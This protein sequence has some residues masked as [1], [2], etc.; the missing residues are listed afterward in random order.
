M[1]K[2]ITLLFLIYSFVSNYAQE[3][4]NKAL[5]IIYSSVYELDSLAGWKYNSKSGQWICRKNNIIGYDDFDKIQIKKISIDDIDYI[6]LFKNYIGGYYEY[7]AINLGWHSTIETGIYGFNKFEF[8]NSLKNIP[9][10]SIFDIKL[11]IDFKV[12]VI[13]EAN[14]PSEIMAT[15]NSTKLSNNDSLIFRIQISK[16]NNYFRLFYFEKRCFDSISDDEFCSFYRPIHKFSGS[17]YEFDKLYNYLFSNKIFEYMYYEGSY[18]EYNKI[19]DSLVK[20]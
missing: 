13:N 19:I 17:I 7:P 18:D 8:I 20:I 10:D 12:L 11:K 1:K 16:S 9:N 14:M 4:V 5:P 6:G 3:R 2:L 15:K